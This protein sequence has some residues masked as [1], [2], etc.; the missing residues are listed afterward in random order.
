MRAFDGS[1]F[2]PPALLDNAARVFVV[3]SR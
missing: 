2:P 3:H 1:S